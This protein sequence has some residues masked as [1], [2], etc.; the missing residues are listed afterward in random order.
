MQLDELTQQNAA[1]VEEAFAASQS[2]AEQAGS[3]NESMAH[4][5]I[6]GGGAAAAV[7]ARRMAG[8]RPWA[9]PK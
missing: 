3:L 8:G 5:A 4:Y 6:S 9:T 1:L 7:P 2:M